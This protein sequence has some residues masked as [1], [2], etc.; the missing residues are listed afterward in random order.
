MDRQAAGAR[1]RLGRTG[2]VALVVLACLMGAYLILAPRV[3]PDEEVPD[4]PVTLHNPPPTGSV[5]EGRSPTCAIGE[6]ES[7][8]GLPVESVDA[9]DSTGSIAVLLVH[10]TGRPLANSPV[11]TAPLA[12]TSGVRTWVSGQTNE[13]GKF[14]FDN[15]SPGRYVVSM[16][17]SNSIHGTLATVSVGGVTQAVIVIPDGNG[18]LRGL[19]QN[20]DGRG[21]EGVEV[22]LRHIVG[23]VTSTYRA[24]TDG[25][26]RYM[27]DYLPCGMHEAVLRGKGMPGDGVSVE[28]VDIRPGAPVEK[29]FLVGADRL[30]GRVIDATTRL[31]IEGAEIR[32]IDRVVKKAVTNV[33]GEY[34]IQDI[35]PGLRDVVVL[36]TGYGR[37]EFRGIVI[38]PEGRVLNFELRKSARIVLEVM[39][40]QGAPYKGRLS[41]SAVKDGSAGEQPVSTMLETDDGGRTTYDGVEPGKYTIL[42]SAKDAGKAF[43]DLDIGPGDNAFTV[44][45]R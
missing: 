44:I 3:G 35:S 12:P 32:V 40:A 41:F 29:D 10:E 15:L 13:E 30:S 22:V 17:V 19:V 7:E 4:R 42:V 25:S 8:S 18:I 33:V 36:A 38:E 34:A 28:T 37:L 20:T 16:S 23:R 26:G 11:R 1:R 27:I 6:G 9:T 39:T 45:L 31:P 2:A 43:M 5:E 24:T 14:S 21:L